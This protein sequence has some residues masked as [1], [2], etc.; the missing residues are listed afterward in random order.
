MKV[1]LHTFGCKA[2]QYDTETVRQAIENAGGFVVDDPSQADAAVVNSCTVTHVAESKMRG[3]VR[4]IARTRPG[5]PTVV[6]GC[7]AAVD[8]GTIAALPGVTGVIGGSDPIA[9]LD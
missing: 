9:V 4:R 3:M 7:A 5:T 1:F 8:D 6:M 2:N